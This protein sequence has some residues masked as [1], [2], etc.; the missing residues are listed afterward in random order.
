MQTQPLSGGIVHQ[1][2][3]KNFYLLGHSITTIFS[4]QTTQ[5]AYYVFE[6]VTPP[7]LG[8]PPHMHER[9]DE[10][11]YLVEGKL[12]ILLGEKTFLAQAGAS[13]F[14]PKGV[15][16]AFQNA[17]SKA[18]KAI[19]TVVPGA[20]F[21]AFFTKLAALPP[22]TPD[23]PQIIAIFAEYGMQVLLPETA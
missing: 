9:E 2:Q 16:H 17:S 1:S 23:L 14:F 6:V 12:E 20:N 5:G 7:G 21:E 3:G 18:A 4:Q 11:I 15:A 13:I 8:L 10:F 22:G 19:F